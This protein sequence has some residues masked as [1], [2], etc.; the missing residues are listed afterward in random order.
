MKPWPYFDEEQI[1]VAAGVLR[2]GRINYWTGEE[3]RAFEQE[4]AAACG[5]EYGIA[6]ANG[7]VALELALKILGIGE[8][9]EVVVTPRSF[10]ASA[11]CVLNAGATPVF[12][13][14]DRDSQN[15]TA[16]TI[17]PV[18]SERTK[19][20]IPVHL[21]GWPCAMAPIMAL[22]EEKGLFVIEDCAQA[23]G[24]AIDGRPVGGHGHLAAFSFCQ[25]K[26]ITTAGEGGM[27]LTSDRD[28]WQRGW[29]FKDHGK[30]Y[31]KVHAKDHPPGFR[32]LHDGL[33]SNWRMTEL[34]AAI[35]RIQLRRLDEWCA[36]RRRFA[37]M[38][39]DAFAGI[40]AFRLTP[41]PA[42]VE[43]A[44]YR[45]Y[46]FLRPEALAAGWDRDRIMQVVADRGVP[47]FSGSCPEIYREHVFDH[48][49][50]RPAGR[51]PAAR[52]LGETSLAFLVHPTLEDEDIRRTIE[53]VS[54]VM[55]EASRVP[56]AREPLAMT[57]GGA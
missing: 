42:G 11:V 39:T 52:E 3:C 15:I 53:A 45:Y 17:R 24:A 1:A 51:L 7:T 44:Y 34:Q 43:H 5:A 14:V 9:D 18:L 41:P 16:E 2:S 48:L 36:R 13:D 6:L 49:P 38:L 50:G 28:F 35:G 26:I 55:A 31:D 4:F 32:W 19:A 8:G 23:H 54:V 20:I 25:D 33:G 27:L 10:Y 37:A 40:P 46:L 47:C 21:G 12:A 30:S 57:A 29:S 22:A 56:L